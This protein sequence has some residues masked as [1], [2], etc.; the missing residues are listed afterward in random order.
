MSKSDKKRAA[1]VPAAHEQ[2]RVK[3]DVINP[4]DHQLPPIATYF[5]AGMPQGVEQYEVYEHGS[6]V[7]ARTKH[8]TV[9]GKQVRM[10]CFLTCD[11]SRCLPCKTHGSMGRSTL[12]GPN[13][14]LSSQYI[15]C[16]RQLA[17][18]GNVDYVGSTNGED[19]TP[20]PQP[21]K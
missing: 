14:S 16:S 11:P 19:H 21:C 20:G 1:D 13:H 17:L 9:L 8:L 15:N 4:E 5:P 3:V 6:G 12:W 7:G 18:K 10:I 2:K